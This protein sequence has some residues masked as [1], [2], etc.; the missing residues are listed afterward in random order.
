MRLGGGQSRALFPLS[1]AIVQKYR[2]TTSLKPFI[3]ALSVQDPHDSPE[4]FREV[5]FYIGKNKT[6]EAL[7]SWRNIN[8]QLH[9]LQMLLTAQPRAIRE[10]GQRYSRPRENQGED[11]ATVNCLEN[12]LTFF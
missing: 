3:T 12:I 2:N 4:A 5:R 10:A 6:Q 9:Q 1:L 11:G 7:S 8:S